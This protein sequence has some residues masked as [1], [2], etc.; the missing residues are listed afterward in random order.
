MEYFW[1]IL[2]GTSAGWLAGQF[3]TREGF[4][5]GGDSIV[6]VIG[7]LIGGIFIEKTGIFSGSG[8][9]GSLVV[10]T[11]GAFVFLYGVR[12]VKSV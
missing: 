5:L 2:I 9:N 4:G 12:L 11:I 10:A 3:M 6:G 7:A 1:F 8:F